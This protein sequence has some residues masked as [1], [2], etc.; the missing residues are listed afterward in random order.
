MQKSL[1][2]IANRVRKIVVRIAPKTNRTFGKP[3]IVESTP[4]A[5][6]SIATNHFLSPHEFQANLENEFFDDDTFLNSAGEKTGNF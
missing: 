2:S 6:N 4:I 1:K 5:S 3:T